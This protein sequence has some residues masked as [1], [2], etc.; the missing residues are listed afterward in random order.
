[1]ENPEKVADRVL[2]YLAFQ[3]KQWSNQEKGKRA[4]SL[5]D[6]QCSKKKLG[7]IQYLNFIIIPEYHC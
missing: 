5:T 4:S 1:M 2:T 7:N 3:S 6:S